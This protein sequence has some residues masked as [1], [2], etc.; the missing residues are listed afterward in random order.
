MQLK[1]Q[2]SLSLPHGSPKSRQQ[3]ETPPSFMVQATPLQHLRLPPGV[4]D[5]PSFWQR[6]FFLCLCFLAAPVAKSAKPAK[7]A[8]SPP[9]AN[10]SRRRVQA[11]KRNPL[12]VSSRAQRQRKRGGIHV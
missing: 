11:S 5:A 12:I 3:R 2:Q 6:F 7:D 8:A 1:L 9:A 10:P 4:H